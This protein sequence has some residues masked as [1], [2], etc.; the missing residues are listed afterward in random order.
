MGD[1]EASARD[2][3]LAEVERARALWLDE[4]EALRVRSVDAVIE[5]LELLSGYESQ[6]RFDIRVGCKLGLALK[7]GL[8]KPTHW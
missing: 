2:L 6:R 1:D 4:D 5:L 7:K 3:V 8:P